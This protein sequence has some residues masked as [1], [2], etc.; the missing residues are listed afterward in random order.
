VRELLE[1]QMELDDTPTP[2]QMSV[3]IALHI[4]NN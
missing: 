3:N 2:S 1:M 4:C